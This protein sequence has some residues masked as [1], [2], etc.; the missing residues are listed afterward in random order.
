MPNLYENLWERTKQAYHWPGFV[1]DGKFHNR[2]YRAGGV[3]RNTHRCSNASGH[4]NYARYHAR[5]K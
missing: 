3:T 5:Y 2:L 4:A 1:F